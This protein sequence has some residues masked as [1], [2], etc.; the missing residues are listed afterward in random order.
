LKGCSCKDPL[1]FSSFFQRLIDKENLVKGVEQL[2]G[3]AYSD[4]GKHKNNIVM[5]KHQHGLDTLGKQRQS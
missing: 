1:F 2:E 5:H 3:D 4:F